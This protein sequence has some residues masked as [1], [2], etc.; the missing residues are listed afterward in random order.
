MTSRFMQRFLLVLRAL[1]VLFAAAAAV[2]A[3]LAYLDGA[4]VPAISLM[5]SAVTFAAVAI[6]MHFNLKTARIQ[7]ETKE[8]LANTCGNCG[9]SG[10]LHCWDRI[11]PGESVE[12]VL[13]IRGQATHG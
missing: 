3:A 4:T 5:L 8:Y 13:P 12:V 1:C 2:L 6:A 10:H 7:S 9:R 11:G